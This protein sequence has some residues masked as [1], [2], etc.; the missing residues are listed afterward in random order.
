MNYETEIYKNINSMNC[1]LMCSICN[2]VPTNPVRCNS[3]CKFVLCK[4]CAI[5]QNSSQ[6][7][8]YECQQPHDYIKLDKVAQFYYSKIGI[9]CNLCKQTFNSLL[10]QKHYN[11]CRQN[12]L[13]Q[14]YKLKQTAFLKNLINLESVCDANTYN[15][16]KQLQQSENDVQNT[17][18]VFCRQCK[19]QV[20]IYDVQNHFNSCPNLILE[21]EFKC[22]W[23]GQRNQYIDHFK[24]LIRNTRE[25]EICADLVHEP[26]QSISENTLECLRCRFNLNPEN[27]MN[28]LLY[29]I[30]FQQIKTKCKCG[31]KKKYWNLRHH[32]GKCEIKNRSKLNLEAHYQILGNIDIECSQ[33]MQITDKLSFTYCCK[34]IICTKCSNLQNKHKC[35]PNYQ[36]VSKVR[37]VGDAFSY[38]V[39]FLEIIKIIYGEFS[40][41]EYASLKA[42]KSQ[43]EEI[44]FFKRKDIIFISRLIIN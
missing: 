15:S 35:Q 31:K 32:L 30:T 21:C 36:S 22:S 13:E 33:C 23:G 41:V 14:S 39:E 17:K 2:Q 24:D 16:I 27:N 6:I 20:P 44:K 8:C 5:R 34:L 4:R 38:G 9:Q 42:Q 26:I 18:L 29:D 43:N 11:K 40:K 7:N 1:L 3:E 37:S 10:Y 25:C 19:I 28:H 12:N